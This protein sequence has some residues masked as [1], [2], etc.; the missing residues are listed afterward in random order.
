MEGNA[1]MKTSL[2]IAFGITLAALANAAAPRPAHALTMA[3]CSAKY[4]A[5]KSAG[6]LN[7]MKWND[8][9]KAQCGAEASA[10]PAAAPAPAAAAPAPAAAPAAPAASAPAA[11]QKPVSAGRQAMIA[12]E[13][14]CG[15]D[16]KEAKAAGKIPAG[17]KWPQYWSE[18]NKRKKAQGM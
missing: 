3:E 12:R 14:A 16:W 5:A 4:K 18:C 7:G 15:A 2:L 1:A 11:G 17:Q 13:R 6:T 9:R 8:F 10:A